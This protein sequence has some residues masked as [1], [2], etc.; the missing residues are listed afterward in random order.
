MSPSARIEVGIV[1]AG[2]TGLCIAHFLERR[3][4]GVR[5]L[6]MSDRPGGVIRSERVNEFLF[7]HGPTSVLKTTPAVETLLA[8]LAITESLEY[9]DPRARRRYIVRGGRLRQL[10]LGPISAVKTDLFSLRAKLRVLKEPFVRPGDPDAEESLAVF[11]KRRLGQE[12]LDYAIDPFVAGVYAG[13]PEDLSV[14]AAFPTLYELEQRFGS[15]IK[16]AIMG[17]R[18]RS[19]RGADSET[20]KGML[21]FKG[22]MQ[23]LVDALGTRLADSIETGTRLKA[24]HR[25]DSDFLLHL[26]SAAGTARLRC[27]AAVLAIPACAYDDVHLDFEPSIHDALKRITYPP[28]SVVFFGYNAN[29]AAVDLRGFGFLVPAREARGILGTLWNSSVF[30]GRA[31]ANGVALTTYIGGGRSPAAATASYDELVAVVQE[32]LRDLLGIERPAD[33]TV[34]KRWP[35]AIPQYNLGHDKIIESIEQLESH[36]PGLFVTGKFRGGISVVDCVDNAREV[37]EQVARAL[38]Q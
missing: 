28:V 19:K 11:V 7:E 30:P 4:I 18:E 22:G 34:V 16:G 17:K 5:V 38:G 26:Q 15:L 27:R 20:R 14:R 35:K 33:V 1:G 25:G 37:S 6:E 31:P 36:V 12:M 3:G 2:I 10:P 32:E 8:D 13:V 9:A 23:T 24:V 21:S 29:P